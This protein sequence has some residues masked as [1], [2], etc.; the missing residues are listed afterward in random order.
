LAVSERLF[1][2]YTGVMN[3]TPR[4]KEAIRFTLK[5]HDGQYRKEMER[6]PYATHVLFAA[7]LLAEAGADEDVVIAALLHDTIEDT[8]TTADEIEQKFGVRV[9]HIV[10]AV[11]EPPKTTTAWR[12]AKEKYIAQ[13]TAADTD[14]LQ[15]SIADKVDNIEAKIEAFER[16]GLELLKQWSQT[17][18]DYLWYHGSILALAQERLPEH[19]LT[20]RLAEAYAQEEALFGPK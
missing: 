16:E 6:W 10:E 1:L 5:K 14:A 15:V 17:P 9:R 20:K 13:V 12:D 7:M 18:Q 8:Q 11:T 2:R 19:P 3:H 4:M